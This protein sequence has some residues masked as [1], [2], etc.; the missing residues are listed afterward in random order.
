MSE[1]ALVASEQKQDGISAAQ[2]RINA[3]AHLTMQAY[4]KA[5]TLV[6][7]KEEVAK[8]QADFADDAF[9][10]GAAGKEN[11]IYIQHA[12]LR[13]RFN[14]VLGIGQWAIVPRSRWNEKF[15][16]E[17]GKDADRVYVEAMLIVRGC[18]VAEAVGDMVYYPDSQS[19]NYGDAVEGA[20]TS[21]FRRCAKEFGVG[22][23]AWKKEFGE[24]WWSRRRAGAKAVPKQSSDPRSPHPEMP[25]DD[26]ISYEPAK[27]PAATAPTVAMRDRMLH[28]LK[29][30]PGEE[31]D[32]LVKEYFVKAG[33]LLPTETLEDL[34]LRF[35][36]MNKD[37]MALL[38]DRIQAFSQGEQAARAF[39]NMDPEPEAGPQVP[40][41]GLDLEDSWKSF[42]VP[43]GKHAG[44]ALGELDKKVLW[45]FWANHTVETEWQGRPRKADQIAKDQA[46]RDALDEAGIHYSFKAK[47]A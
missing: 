32:D 47:A 25:A 9:Q 14:E 36:P 13:D 1:E 20:K 2:A 3:V 29:A 28:L 30:L 43:F 27:K 15:K 37:Q 33:C 45:G 22:L 4:E 42:P 31:N 41:E 16:T 7:A 10:P 35:V 24:G 40:K 17:K 23:Q 18:F 21:A 44:M 6:L 26:D 34:P 19:Q 46:F 11:L 12:C 8:L 39:V 38:S 5:S